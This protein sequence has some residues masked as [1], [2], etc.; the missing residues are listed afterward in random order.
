MCGEKYRKNDFRFDGEGTKGKMETKKTLR[1]F[2]KE[3]DGKIK[4]WENI[5]NYRD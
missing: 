5:K 4:Y 1:K 3:D 2:K